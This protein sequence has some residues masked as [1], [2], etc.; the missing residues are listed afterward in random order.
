MPN[1]VKTAK[2]KEVP[3]GTRKVVRVRGRRIVLVNV[4]GSFYA[5]D[6]ECVHAGAP[7]NRGYL[8]G[9]RLICPWHDWPYDVRTGKL[10]HNPRVGVRTYPTKVENG[11]IYIDYM[12]DER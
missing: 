12:E 8:D 6:N 10:P 4:E 7:L 1:W 3:P 5:L 11:R 2:E 9:H